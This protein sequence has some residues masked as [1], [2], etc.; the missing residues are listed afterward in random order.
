MLTLIAT[1]PP[2]VSVF[3]EVT[4]IKSLPALGD[5]VMSKLIEPPVISALLAKLNVSAVPI[6]PGTKVPWLCM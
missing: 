2:R 6:A 1:A 3:G 4:L 5:E